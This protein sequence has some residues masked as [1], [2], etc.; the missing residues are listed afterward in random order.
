MKGLKVGL[1]FGITSGVISTLGMIAGLASSTQSRIAVIGGIITIAIADAMSD[2]FGIHISSE[3]RRFSSDKEVWV[4]TI[5]TLITKMITALTFIVP[6]IYFSF[7]NAILIN[8]CWGLIVLTILSFL[9]AK[10]QGES[11]AR[12]ILEHIIIGIIVILLSAG[13]GNFVRDF[14]YNS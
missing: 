13:V 9:I 11:P 12:V 8:I 2:A 14:F 5:S 1:S 10:K 4:S 6:V 3:S 7:F